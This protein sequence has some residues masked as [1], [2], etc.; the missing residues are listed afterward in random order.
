MTERKIVLSEDLKA[1]ALP[2]PGLPHIK[3]VKSTVG[4]PPTEPCLTCSNCCDVSPVSVDDVKI[5]VEVY[6]KAHR[7]CRRLSVAD[8]VHQ[9]YMAAKMREARIVVELTGGETGNRYTS[10]TMPMDVK[11]KGEPE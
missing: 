10:D 1:P 8:D 11:V 2:F 9:E 3:F 4:P 6:V 7:E 5:H